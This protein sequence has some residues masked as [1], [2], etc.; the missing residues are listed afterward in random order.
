MEEAEN[1]IKRFRFLA[2]LDFLQLRNSVLFRFQL[3]PLHLLKCLIVDLF[4]AVFFLLQPF[5]TFSIANFVLDATK[6]KMNNG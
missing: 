3:F 1:E 5:F 4:K 6:Y 2:W